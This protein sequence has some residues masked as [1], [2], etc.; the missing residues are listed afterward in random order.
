MCLKLTDL[1]TPFKIYFTMEMVRAINAVLPYGDQIPFD[2]N[3]SPRRWR[4]MLKWA[5]TRLEQND[6]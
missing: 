3:I 6:V 2:E 4:A 5:T 1:N